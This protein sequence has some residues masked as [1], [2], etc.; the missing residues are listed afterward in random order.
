VSATIAAPRAP[1]YA[2]LVRRVLADELQTVSKSSLGIAGVERASEATG[3]WDVPGS[4]HIVYT[5]D[6]SQAREEV[7]AAEAPHRF[8]YR[9]T[10]FTQPMIRRLATQA[11]GEWRFT[12]AGTGTLVRWDYAFEASAPWALPVLLPLIKLLFRRYMRST[13]RS[14]QARAEAEV[15]AAS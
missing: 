2:W 11:H 15:T 12:D 1:L 7:T 13:L 14:I 9:V 5:S 3:P 4:S 8:A 10:E 6:G